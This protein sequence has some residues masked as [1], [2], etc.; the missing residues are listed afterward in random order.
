MSSRIFTPSD[1]TKLDPQ[2]LSL[3]LSR[4]TVDR[5]QQ[6]LPI[7]TA[8]Q[9]SQYS[10]AISRTIADYRSAIPPVA[11]QAIH[12][13]QSER[14]AALS[15]TAADRLEKAK[16]LVADS[17]SRFLWYEFTPYEI[18]CDEIGGMFVLRVLC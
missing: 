10:D 6:P 4:R 7:Y 15:K 13:L 9:H 1:L 8:I 16:G 14:M 18:G 3:H 17:N 2:H 5:G 12:E 11:V